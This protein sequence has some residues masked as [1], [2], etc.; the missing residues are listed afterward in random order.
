L[1][2]ILNIGTAVPNNSLTQDEFYAKYETLI[3]DDKT[4]RKLN[5]LVNR[6][7]ISKRHCV[8]TNLFELTKLSIYEKLNK[9]HNH[10]VNLA[11]QAILANSAFEASKQKITDIITIS[12]TGMQAPGVEIDLINELGL[13]S[14]IRRYNINFMGCYAAITGLRLAH[15]ICSKPNRTVLLVSVELCTLHFQ[16]AS[17]DDYLLSNSL[18]ADGSASVIISS[19][20]SDAKLQLVDFES[21]IIPKTKNDMSWKIS[22]TGFLMTLSAAVPSQ[23]QNSLALK[24]LF[25]KIP[26]E[27]NWAIHPGG[28]QIVSGIQKLL[29]LDKEQVEHSFKILKTYGNMS[30]A[31]ILFVLKEMLSNPQNKYK[32]IVG[33]AFGPGLTLESMLLEYV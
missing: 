22:D 16:A 6:S 10:A 32:E 11:K 9:Y 33:C 12:C 28:K 31:T 1:A 27:V 3:D 29:S 8:D 21:R 2:Y 30:S 24:S 17:S 19:D 15:E 23:I 14:S 7:A 26:S 4:R 20:K 18:F 13:N 5:F 25:N